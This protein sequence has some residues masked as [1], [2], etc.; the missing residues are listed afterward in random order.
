MNASIAVSSETSTAEFLIIRHLWIYALNVSPR[1]CTQA[2]T[3]SMDA[4]RLYVDLK[5]LVNCFV[6]SS[7]LPIVSFPSFLNHDL[8]AP[9]RCNCKLCIAV[10]WFLL[11]VLLLVDNLKAM[12][13]APEIRRTFDGQ[14]VI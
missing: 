3:S 8:D 12:T 11:I 7:Q 13:V 10:S 5:L 2:L 14:G 4:G 9:V 1:C 6:S